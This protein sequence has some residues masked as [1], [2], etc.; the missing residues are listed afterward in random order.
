MRAVVRFGR[1][2]VAAGMDVAQEAAAISRLFDLAGAASDNSVMGSPWASESAT[3]KNKAFIA[4]YKEK[5]GIDADQF[6]AQA[7]DALY[8]MAEALKA[9]NLTGNLEKDRQALRDALPAVKYTGATGPFSFR[10]AP[11]KAGA[12]TGYDAQQEAHIF[13]AK[14]GKFVLMK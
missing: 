2:V 9:V 1:R 3:P 6:A 14:G 4:A 7:Y 5:F 13:I 12:E 11:P 8:I 10:K